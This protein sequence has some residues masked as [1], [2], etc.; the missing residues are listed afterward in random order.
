MSYNNGSGVF[1]FQ[2]ADLSS[3][4][5][6]TGVLSSHTDVNNAS[7]TDGQV[8]TW[9]NSNSYWKPADAA[10]G[11]AF[12][13]IAVSG[14]SDV[15][16][17]SSS[18]TLTLVAGS[19][20]VLTTNAGSDSIT[21]AASGGGGGTTYEEFKINYATNGTIASI[22]NESSDISSVSIDSAA[23]GDVTV[24]FQNY[25]TPPLSIMFYG[26]NYASNEYN[27]NTLGST[28]TTLRTVPGGGSSGSPTAFGSFSS[29][30]LKVREAETG[31]SRSFGTTTHACISFVIGESKMS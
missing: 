21:V 9:D 5:T 4:L 2:P 18:D 1:T 16:A 13:T 15:V 20:I 28:G 29:L 25:T 3:Y 23:G 19:G 17:D 14:Q 12:K 30:K 11:E 7:P 27:M 26:Y 24:N 6:S 31:A 10:G 8:L 22:S